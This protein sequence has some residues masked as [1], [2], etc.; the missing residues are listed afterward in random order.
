M[1]KKNET[2][3]R[4]RKPPLVFSSTSRSVLPA[5]FL[6][7]CY[8]FY[9]HDNSARKR[10][11]QKTRHSQFRPGWFWIKQF[12]VGPGE[13]FTLQGPW[14]FFEFIGALWRPPAVRFGNWDRSWVWAPLQNTLHC[15]LFAGWKIGLSQTPERNLKILFYRKD[16]LT[17]SIASGTN[18]FSNNCNLK[19]GS[20]SST[21][22]STWRSWTLARIPR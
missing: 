3:H 8:H 17:E 11:Q 2:G 15:W 19:F 20:K 4:L 14:T 9:L 22:P 13:Y 6:W 10:C 1:Q 5:R 21:T 18:R 7:R 12:S 16:W